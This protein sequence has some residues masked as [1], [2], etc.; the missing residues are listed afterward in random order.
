MITFAAKIENDNMISNKQQQDAYFICITGSGSLQPKAIRFY[1]DY[2]LQRWMKE[3]VVPDAVRLLYYRHFD[4]V[5]DALAHKLMLENLCIASL[6]C[7]ISHKNPGWEDLHESM[8]EELTP[9][10]AAKMNNAIT[11]ND[12]DNNNVI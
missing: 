11:P 6:N 5:F 8:Q 2:N 12:N 3:G 7:I 10:L 4:N 9:L 1:S